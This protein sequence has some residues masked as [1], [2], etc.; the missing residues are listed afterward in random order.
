[1]K[2]IERTQQYETNGKF[3][4]VCYKETVKIIRHKAQMICNHSLT[5]QLN[6]LEASKEK[7]KMDPRVE[8]SV[9]KF[10]QPSKIYIDLTQATTKRNP[11]PTNVIIPSPPALPPSINS[12]NRKPTTSSLCTTSQFHEN[13]AEEDILTITSGI[14]PADGLAVQTVKTLQSEL[15]SVRTVIA[16]MQQE[17]EAT[18]SEQTAAYKRE[19]MLRKKEEEAHRA[20]RAKVEAEYQKQRKR[21][22]QEREEEERCLRARQAKEEAEYKK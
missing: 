17:M 11:I 20:Q 13:N 9:R 18:K 21:E 10:Y 7:Y 3:F 8:G 19:R 1:M 22:K 15:A 12:W 14:T 2:Y 6:E 4:F 5:T 16:G